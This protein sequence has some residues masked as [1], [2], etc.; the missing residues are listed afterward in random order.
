MHRKLK[1]ALAGAAT[2]IG[3]LVAAPAHADTNCQVGWVWAYDQYDNEMFSTNSPGTYYP[4]YFDTAEMV[5]VTTMYGVV[6]L[7]AG[8][9]VDP[10]HSDV[11]PHFVIQY[12]TFS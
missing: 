11:Y 1:A 5:N 8:A 9:W 12:I 4:G 3:A 7:G 10:P 2:L 6:K